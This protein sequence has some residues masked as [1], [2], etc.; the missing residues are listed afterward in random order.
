LVGRSSKESKRNQEKK[1]RAD[2]KKIKQ[3]KQRAM[4][5]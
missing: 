2:N 4:N 1:Q 3:R 5:L